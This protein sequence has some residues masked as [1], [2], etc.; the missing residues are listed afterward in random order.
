[1]GNMIQQHQEMDRSKQQQ[2]CSMC[3][4]LQEPQLSICS[5]CCFC[6]VWAHC[7]LCH[8]LFPALTAGQ[9]YTHQN[10]S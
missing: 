1:M 2:Q 4:L 10:Q 8:G 9:S 5:Q 6:P 7:G 3:H